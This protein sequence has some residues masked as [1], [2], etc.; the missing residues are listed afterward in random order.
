MLAPLNFKSL[1]ALGDLVGFK[2]LEMSQNEIENMDV[3][4]KEDPDRFI[5][6]ALRDAVICVKY[7]NEIRAIYS[8]LGLGRSSD[9]STDFL[10]AAPVIQHR[11]DHS[12][13]LNISSRLL[14]ALMIFYP[15][16]SI[17]CSG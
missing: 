9:D 14:E 8:K 10:M 12:A 3:I 17:I 16:I 2:K 11:E 5:D 4:R 1:K 7:L 15:C 6:Y 13:S